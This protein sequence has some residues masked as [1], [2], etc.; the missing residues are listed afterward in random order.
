MFSSRLLLR[1]VN[2]SD[3]FDRKKN[4]MVATDDW[5]GGRPLQ[6]GLPDFSWAKHSELGKI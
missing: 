1:L 2:Q 6:A 3:Q 5:A 4:L